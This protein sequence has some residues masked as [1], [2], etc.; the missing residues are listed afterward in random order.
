MENRS[1]PL[2]SNLEHLNEV[3]ARVIEHGDGLRSHSR[4][5]HS[6]RDT[7]PVHPFELLLDVVDNKPCQRYPLLEESLLVCP[8]GGILVWL[9][10]GLDVVW[11][12]RRDDRYPSELAHRYL[13]SKCRNMTSKGLLSNPLSLW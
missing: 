6:E 1:F 5:L 11:P 10:E 2:P 12:F 3:T 8:G 9:K 7:Q 13:H 4:W